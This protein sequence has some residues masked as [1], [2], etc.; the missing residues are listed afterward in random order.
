MPQNSLEGLLQHYLLHPAFRVSNSVSLEW[1]PR[2]CNADQIPKWSR[3]CWSKNHTLRTS[4]LEDSSQVVPNLYNHFTIIYKKLF[5]FLMIRWQK[6]LQKQ[7]KTRITMMFVNRYY[8]EINS[9]P[10]SLLGFSISCY[11]KTQ[12]FGQPNMLELLQW[13]KMQFFFTRTKIW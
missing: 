7:I 5:Q 12:F 13:E 3:C 9:K 6:L 4:A 2:I 8:F 11:R 1:G 10:K